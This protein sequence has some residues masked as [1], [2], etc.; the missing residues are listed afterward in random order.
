MEA[1]TQELTQAGWPGAL[2]CCHHTLLSTKVPRDPSWSPAEK[3]PP[4]RAACGSQA[5]SA[6][7]EP[8]GTDHSSRQPCQGPSPG[9]NPA[10][11]GSR[12][13][14]A[15][16]T[17]TGGENPL[18]TRGQGQVEMVEEKQPARVTSHAMGQDSAAFRGAPSLSSPTQVSARRLNPSPPHVL[19]Q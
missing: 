14:T 1:Y 3:A 6:L 7:R 4:Q 8:W 5:A 12:V 11:T 16:L 17:V 2:V 9:A 13:K 18:L 19:N 10:W 15:E